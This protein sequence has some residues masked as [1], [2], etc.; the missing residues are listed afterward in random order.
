MI[1][2]RRPLIAAIV[3]LAAATPAAC[4]STRRMSSHAAVGASG[5]SMSGPLTGAATASN[6]AATMTVAAMTT[7]A[8][9]KSTTPAVTARSLSTAPVDRFPGALT[10]QWQTISRI[11]GRP[12]IWVAERAGVTLVRMDQR[13]VHLALHAGSLDPGGSGWRYG[14]VVAGR[15]IHHLAF[16]FNGGFKFST[17]AGGFFSFGRTAVPLSDGF[18]SVVTYRDGRS[19]IGAWR[20]GVPAGGRSIASVRQNLHLLIDHGQPD[21]SVTSCGAGCWGATIGGLSAVARSGLGIRAAGQLVWAAGEGLTVAQLAEAMV[22]AGVQ[23]GVQLDIN[24]DWVAGYLY[25]HHRTSGPTPIPVV[26]GQYG[27]AGQLLQPYTRDFFT[28]LSN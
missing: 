15:E 9:G 8:K 25:I 14:D 24:P 4:G 6:A 28:V 11:D 26:P 17:G 16:G 10:S 2:V 27:I 13:F 3:A 19:D 22:G 7:V 20:Q 1:A 18:G 12:A 5:Q 23:R 21:G